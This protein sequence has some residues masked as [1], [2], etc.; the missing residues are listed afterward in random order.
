MANYT[1][2]WDFQNHPQWTAVWEVWHCTRSSTTTTETT[3]RIRKL[4]F[5]DRKFITALPRAQSCFTNVF[6]AGEVS[7]EMHPVNA[8]SFHPRSSWAKPLLVTHA[9]I[10]GS[11]TGPKYMCQFCTGVE[12]AAT[13]I[14]A[15]YYC[16]HLWAQGYSPNFLR[17][18]QTWWFW[19]YRFWCSSNVRSILLKFLPTKSQHLPQKLHWASSGESWG[20]M[21]REKQHRHSHTSEL[22][23]LWT[24]QP[25]D[26]LNLQLCPHQG[27]HWFKVLKTS[28]SASVRGFGSLCAEGC[29]DTL[30]MSSKS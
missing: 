11:N 28:I 27:I 4:L 20:W 15:F 10:Q 2:F 17:Q 21:L 29:T 1:N 23:E 8:V 5:F 18:F 26:A 14:R 25:R 3:T 12:S 7:A 9:G 30:T 13:H 19:N 16:S 6:K 24:N 22:P